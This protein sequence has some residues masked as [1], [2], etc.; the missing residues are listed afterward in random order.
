M[1]DPLFVI[2]VSGR[3]EGAAPGKSHGTDDTF[4]RCAWLR[5][6]ELVRTLFK[7]R[8]KPGAI[9]TGTSVLRFIHFACHNSSVGIYEHDFATMSDRVPDPLG[10]SLERNWRALDSSF[11]TKFGTLTASQDPST[12]VEWQAVATAKAASPSTWGK[13]D[14]P[15]AN[16]SIVNAYHSIR[17]APSGSIL[18]FSI[19]S[20]AF[21]D[22]PVLNNTDA[23]PGQ[24]TRT[25][26]DSDGRASIDFQA[27]MGET[28]AANA[29]ALK[30]FVAAFAP[31]GSFRIWGCNIQDIVET[32]PPEGGAARRCLIR[33]TVLEVVQE[34]YA[35]PLRSGGTQARLLRDRTH[36]LPGGTMVNIDM[37]RQISHEVELQTDRGAGHGLTPFTKARL[38]EIRYSEAI[39]NHA[40]AAF[41]RNEQNPA[42]SG[43]FA[44]TISR[45]YSDV[46][47][48]VAAETT[49]TYF[50][51]AA[52]A[53]RTVTVISGAPGTSAEIEGG[54]QFIGPTTKVQ[55]EFFSQ[56]FGAPALEPSGDS[57]VQRHY[58]ILDNQGNAVKTILDREA[59]GLP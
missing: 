28:G 26:G 38:F 19:F 59:N 6:G 50:F 12:F 56:F 58:S 40:Y 35:K 10:R 36:L 57:E 23:T 1:A 9:V 53:M 15:P 48:F 45:S 43:T 18:E 20:H 4:A 3:P 8:K 46:V 7:K 13:D 16:V 49:K 30:E 52:Q 22:G 54:Q 27:N 32:V 21:V 25:P 29:N 47:K 17:R 31:T 37:D 5:V 39:P 51:A 34:T 2:L 41:F 14:D 33:S 24:T 44:K 55:A 42:G 11:A